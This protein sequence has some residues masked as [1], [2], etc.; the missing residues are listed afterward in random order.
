MN[1]KEGIDYFC[2][3]IINDINNISQSTRK[4]ELIAYISNWKLLLNNIKSINK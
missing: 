1:K 3:E 4:N 2:D